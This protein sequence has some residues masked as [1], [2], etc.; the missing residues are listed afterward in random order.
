MMNRLQ[1]VYIN[2]VSKSLIL[3]YFIR[4]SQILP[5]E[6]NRGISTTGA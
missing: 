3:Q 5:A 1:I 6:H 4:L 2:L